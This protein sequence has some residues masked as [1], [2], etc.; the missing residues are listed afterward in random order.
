MTRSKSEADD[1]LQVGSRVDSPVDGD[2]IDAPYKITIKLSD[3]SYMNMFE[4]FYTF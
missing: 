3:N 1:F 2:K 4:D